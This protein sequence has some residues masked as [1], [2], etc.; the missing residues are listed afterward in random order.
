MKRKLNPWQAPPSLKKE[1]FRKTQ[2]KILEDVPEQTLMVQLNTNDNIKSSG[3]THIKYKLNKL[4]TQGNAEEL[5]Q[6]GHLDIMADSVGMIKIEDKKIW[7]TLGGYE[8]QLF[9]KKKGFFGSSELDN[10]KIKLNE[11]S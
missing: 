2:A 8:L 9:L 7:K 11:L 6:E 4:E 3:A 1:H 5:F 10:T